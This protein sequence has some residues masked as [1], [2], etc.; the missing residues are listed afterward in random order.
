MSAEPTANDTSSL[1]IDNNGQLEKEL[2]ETIDANRDQ[3]FENIEKEVEKDLVEI[4]HSNLLR[5]FHHVNSPS[6]VEP[7]LTNLWISQIYTFIL[8]EVLNIDIRCFSV[9]AKDVERIEYG[10][11]SFTTFVKLWKLPFSIASS[12]NVSLNGSNQMVLNGSS[13][14]LKRRFTDI[15]IENLSK[16]NYEGYLLKNIKQMEDE[17]FDRVRKLDM[18]SYKSELKYLL[19]SSLVHCFGH[20]GYRLAAASENGLASQ[21]SNRVISPVVEFLSFVFSMT[22]THHEDSG[23]GFGNTLPGDSL[24]KELESLGVSSSHIDKVVTMNSGSASE[25]GRDKKVLFIEHRKAPKVSKMGSPDDL[26]KIK[27]I[28]LQVFSYKACSNELNC[29]IINDLY[30]SLLVFFDSND[31]KHTEDGLF[32]LKNVQSYQ[33][34][35]VEF[36]YQVDDN[37]KHHLNS[38][39][40][41]S[42]MI[43]MEIKKYMKKDSEKGTKTTQ[44]VSGLELKMDQSNYREPLKVLNSKVNESIK[45]LNLKKGKKL[46]TLKSDEKSKG[47]K[48]ALRTA[49]SGEAKRK[50][51]L[52]P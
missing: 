18:Y 9:N 47:Q 12:T 1:G 35:D 19:Q 30:G 36:F 43:Y 32:T 44:P 3:L 22:L 14:Q 21:F 42:M 37:E 29:G 5:N 45:D 34:N 40:I 46:S 50:K 20:H 13:S 52:R 39:I 28:L 26:E 48:R 38:R 25:D 2:E 16:V 11:F 15:G 31:F 23:L 33:V 24:K 8:R 10:P 41:V 6:S 27:G 17:I 4:N 7:Q 49:T 51:G